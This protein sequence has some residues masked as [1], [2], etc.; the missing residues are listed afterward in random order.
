M[1]GLL[2]PVIATLIADTREYMAKMTEAQGKMTEFGVTAETTGG[3]LTKFGNKATTAIIGVGAAMI[4][5]GIDSALKYTESLDKIQNQSNASAAEIEFL[6][7]AIMNVSNETTIASDKIAEAFLIVEKAGI[8]GANGYALVDAAAKAAV[9]TGGDVTS[10]TKT[11]V[12]A[13][14]LQIAKGMDVAAISDLMVNANKAHIGS[15]DSL[16]SVLKGKVGGALAAVGVNMAEAAAISDIASK[17]GYESGRAFTTIATGM[18]KIENPT[19]ASVKALKAFGL[20]ANNLAKTAKTPGTGVIDVLKQLEQQSIKTGKPLNE[21]I[22]A[23]FGKGSVGIISTL[24]KQI[25]QLA[26]LNNTLNKSTGADLNTTFG[27]TSSQLNFKLNQL[28]NEAKNVLTGIGLFFLPTVTDLANWAGNAVKFFQDHPLIK[29]IASDSAILLFVGSI[30]YK[31]GSAIMDMVSKIT[32]TTSAA[33]TSTQNELQIGILEEIALNTAET[34]AA[35]TASDI[36]SSG[37]NIAQIGGTLKDMIPGAAAEAAW[38][39]ALAELAVIAAAIGALWF[40]FHLVKSQQTAIQLID[41]KSNMRT[42]Y[43]GTKSQSQQVNLSTPYGNITA[44]QAFAAADYVKYKLHDTYST[45]KNSKYYK[46][47]MV[48]FQ[49]FA[50]A[51]VGKKTTT[52]VK[53][54]VKAG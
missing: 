44:A 35:L 52:N 16:V 17:A 28:K 38:L 15:L 40:A 51:D 27:M 46:D 22:G 30:A 23:T 36:L 13:Q 42:G 32:G 41:P 54:T 43:Q 20:D 19:K 24:I 21:I 7:T 18:Q 50:K 47:I 49:Q 25:P 45:D 34:A 26:T 14:T 10:V 11:I 2:P 53:I 6:K 5:Y 4:G 3:K 9:I 33:L 37:S 29:T 39:P 12:A 1:A 31:L 8:T 48:Q